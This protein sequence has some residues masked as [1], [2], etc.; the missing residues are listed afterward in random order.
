MRRITIAVATALALGA[1][2]IAIPKLKSNVQASPV[3]SAAAPQ[4]GSKACTNVKFK[5]TNNRSDKATIRIEK[6]Y[7]KV[8]GKDHTE[9][10]HTSNDCKYG[11][12]C[13]TTGDNLPDADGRAV[14]NIQL[15]YRFL[16]PNV[17]NNWSDLVHTPDQPAVANATCSDRRTYGDGAKGFM[18]PPQ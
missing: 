1:L 16:P 13:T 10:V 7:Y 5:F 12:T 4:L 2:T 3:A 14:T 9:D 17:G 8:I 18:I 11:A 15:A 6:V